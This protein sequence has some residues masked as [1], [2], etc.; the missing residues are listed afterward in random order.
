MGTSKPCTRYPTLATREA[1]PPYDS[2][3]GVIDVLRG[4]MDSPVSWSK[5]KLGEMTAKNANWTLLNSAPP[6]NTARKLALNVLKLA[7]AYRPLE[8]SLITA[9]ADG[10]IGIVYK[11][12]QRYAAIECLNINQIWLLWFDVLNQPQSR[13]V[14]VTRSEIK[15]ALEELSALHNNA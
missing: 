4:A 2:L 14:K 6:N 12:D 3:I 13:R 7:H 11:S 1:V 9:S 10:G 15:K 5:A 8:P